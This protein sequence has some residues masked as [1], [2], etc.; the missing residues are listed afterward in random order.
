MSKFKRILILVNDIGTIYNFRR[1]LA[2]RLIEEGY[3]VIVSVPEH[4][5]CRALEDMGC[6]IEPITLSRHGTNPID[7]LK[8]YKEYK[9]LLKRVQPDV[10]LTYTAKPNIYG[11]FACHKLKIPV[12][13]NVP[14]LGKPFQSE[15]LLKKVLLFMQKRAFK[16]SK[17]V[18][19]QNSENL[20]VFTDSNAIGSQA[21]LLPGS[22]VNLD[23][24]EFTP[25]PD[26]S[27]TVKF[28]F[29][30]RLRKDKGYDEFFAAVREVC[31]KY[32]NAEF[33]V[34]GALE[35]QEYKTELEFMKKNFPLVYHGELS[36]EQVH[37]VVKMCHCV[38][39]PSYHEGMSN[40]LLEGASSGRACLCSD[41]PGCKEIVDNGETG[42]VF[43]VKSSESLRDALEKFMLLSH[44]QREQMG[45]RGRQKMER[46]FD[47]NI[48][49][50]AYLEEI[51][52]IEN[53]GN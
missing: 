47:R 32:P 33:H 52:K 50:N 41:I 37:E 4:P 8:L 29:V 53:G 24:H 17:C 35:Q 39:H 49:I 31:S 12:I 20:K 15:S 42:F 2:K 22:G 5:L 14:G 23:L 45:I 11:S 25:Y 16:K 28:V 40:A 38:V 19:F 10:V 6:K 30:S 46:E 9:R 3:E 7:E 43:E 27:E 48:I 44:E 1:E 21:R 18:F 51:A 13:N 34:I 26:D 36:Q